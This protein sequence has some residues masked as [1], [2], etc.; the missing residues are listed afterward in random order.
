MRGLE[1]STPFYFCVHEFKIIFKSSFLIIRGC[2]MF[3]HTLVMAKNDEKKDYA[4]TQP[5]SLMLKILNNG[6]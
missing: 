2:P 4:E 3:I 5:S 6:K 1:G